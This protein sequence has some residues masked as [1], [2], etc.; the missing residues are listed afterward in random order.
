MMPKHYALPELDS[1][2]CLAWVVRW[3]AMFIIAATDFGHGL[4]LSL[5]LRFLPW[6]Q[7]WLTSTVP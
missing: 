3:I 5:Q 1:S 7:R 6:G 4:S 2:G